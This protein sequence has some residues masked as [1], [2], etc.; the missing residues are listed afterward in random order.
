MQNSVI[1]LAPKT[2][3]KILYY[4]TAPVFI[5]LSIYL[6]YVHATKGLSTETP[7][8]FD[9]SLILSAIIILIAYATSLPVFHRF[10]IELGEEEIVQYALRKKIIPFQNI[11]RIVV[12]N[13]GLEIHGKNLFN[14]I[15]IGNLYTNFDE[16]RNA[17]GGVASSIENIKLKGNSKQIKSFLNPS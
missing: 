8:I 10:R 6:L 1:V 9:L 12:R 4:I 16:A 13:G 7:L 17:L 2:W 3:V 15:S 11:K 5:T 14:R